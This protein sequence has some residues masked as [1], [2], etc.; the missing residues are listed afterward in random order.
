MKENMRLAVL[1]C[2]KESR[3]SD[4]LYEDW[5]EEVSENG[6]GPFEKVGRTS[7]WHLAHRTADVEAADGGICRQER[8]G[9]VL[10][11]H[12]GE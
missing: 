9:V 8:V 11:F 10:S 7:R 3:L 5:C 1:I 2:Q 12:G 6:L 4:E